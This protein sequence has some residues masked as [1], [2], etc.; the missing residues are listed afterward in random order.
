MV[1]K[2]ICGFPSLLLTSRG[3]DQY[4]MHT[5]IADVMDLG[6]LEHLN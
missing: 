4:N 1:R 6:A 2:T 5:Y 3:E